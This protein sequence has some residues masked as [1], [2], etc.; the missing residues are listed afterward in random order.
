MLSCLGN[1]RG[2][3]QVV[4]RGTATLLAA[5]VAAGVPRMAMVSCVGVGDSATQLRSTGAIGW[6]HSIMF[7]TLLSADREDL[8]AAEATCL[9]QPRGGDVTC[10]VVRA[11]DLTDGEGVGSY[12]VAAATEAVGPSVAR[13]DVARFL[14]SLARDDQHDGR[15]VSVSQSQLASCGAS[16]YESMATYCDSAYND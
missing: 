8:A 2:E 13:E 6:L 1:R 15:A 16:A 7:A 14:L 12:H 4:H 9:G 10:V 3:P 5:M 11:A